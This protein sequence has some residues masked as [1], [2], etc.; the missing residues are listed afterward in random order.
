VILVGAGGSIA[1]SNDKGDSFKQY[2]LP[3]RSSLSSVIALDSGQFLLVGQGGVH[4][5]D[6]KSVA[7]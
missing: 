3:V 6:V 2:I 1:I 5:F 7:E 4:H